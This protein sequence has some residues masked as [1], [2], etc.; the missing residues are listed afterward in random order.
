MAEK[1]AL[2]KSRLCLATSERSTLSS[3]QAKVLISLVLFQK[4][5]MPSCPI[6]TSPVSQNEDS[7][8]KSH[9]AFWGSNLLNSK[10]RAMHVYTLNQRLKLGN[11]GTCL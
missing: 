2:N 4:G 11:G 1:D 8:F 10:H 3:H 9:S 7:P 5:Q 6:A